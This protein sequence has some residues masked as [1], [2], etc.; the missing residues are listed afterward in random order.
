MTRL[1]PQTHRHA[2]RSDQGHHRVR[3][4]RDQLPRVVRRQ[5][6]RQHVRQ[7]REGVQLARRPRLQERQESLQRR[8]ARLRGAW[9]TGSGLSSVGMH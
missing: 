4:G 9:T 1:P 3:P 5:L 7:R 8:P 6:V 2:E